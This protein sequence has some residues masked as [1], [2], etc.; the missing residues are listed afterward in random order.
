[1][2]DPAFVDAL[3]FIGGITIALSAPLQLYRSCQTRS[4]KDISFG[5]ITSYLIGIYLICI[6]GIL[7]N[8]PPIWGPV[9]LEI[10]CG[11]ALMVLKVKLD[12]FEKK[13]Y[14]RTIG[15]QTGAEVVEES[16]A[17]L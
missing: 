16:A 17:R 9:L 10:F 12:L 14:S 4:T 1:M 2:A 5:W 3:G 6:Y 13:S 15:T 11:T 8:L 7:A